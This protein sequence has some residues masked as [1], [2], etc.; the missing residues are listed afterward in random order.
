MIN[1][2]KQLL[3][4][5]KEETIKII[6]SKL[7]FNVIFC[8][9]L[10]LIFLSNY[11]YKSF[12]NITIEQLLFSIQ[13]S[14][15]TDTST[16]V[17]G[18]I[19]VFSLMSIVYLILCSII[20]FVKKF[21]HKSI[22]NGKVDKTKCNPYLLINIINIVL[23]ISVIIFISNKIGLSDYLLNNHKSTVFEEHYVDPKKVNI[24]AS[25][26][27]RN[28]IFIY[29]ESGESTFVSKKNGGA[30]EKS[31]TPN[32]EK[33]A[34]NNINF[35]YNKKIGGASMVTGTNWT[36]A[37]IISTTSG[38]PF[39]LNQA[40]NISNEKKG[41]LPGAYA[42][43]DVLKDNGYQNYVMMGSYAVFGNREN[44]F[45]A[46]GKYNIYD[47]EY[48]IDHNWL[49]HN[50]KKWWGYEDSK[51]FKFAKDEL[52]I[53]SKNNKPFNLTLLTVDTHFID[54]YI[55]E[56]CTVPFEKKYLNAY[57]CSDY[58]LGD[59]ISWVKKQNFYENTTIVITGDHLTMQANI[60]DM[61]DVKKN[62]ERYIYNTFINSYI[63][64][65]NNKNRKFNSMDIYPTTL[66]ALGFEIEG[67]RLGLGTNLFSS[68]KTLTE[69]KGFNY[70][71]KELKMKSDFY[72]EKLLGN[73]YKQ[74]LL[75]GKTKSK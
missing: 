22:L 51:L 7:F 46:H 55:E 36:T 47:Y 38:V 52:K 74:M 37:G 23:L 60:V 25:K 48:A 8:I 54:G 30:F 26:Q 14:E 50:Y 11:I 12:S 63:N 24:I 75:D 69:E 42:I 61:F 58:Y 53:I 5:L 10:F 49:P 41:L 15:G 32:L 33:L 67:D 17:D 43:G 31:I 4:I 66:A 72:N 21:F 62:Y 16:I 40:K 39:K 35:S 27:K 65:D 18:S 68:R 71:E 45:K 13:T 9:L 20:N 70:I 3:I 6:R 2:L 19:Y 34:Y 44:Y 28:L 56:Q 59:F 29:I 64:T 73:T 1:Q 57:Y